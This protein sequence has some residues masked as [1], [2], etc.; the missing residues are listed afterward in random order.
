MTLIPSP[1]PQ[2][3]LVVM[4]RRS[5]CGIP[6]IHKCPFLLSNLT[7]S[8]AYSKHISCLSSGFRF[9]SVC[10]VRRTAS[11]RRLKVR[12]CSPAV[13]VCIRPYL[14]SIESSPRIEL[15]CGLCLIDLRPIAG[16][17][18]I[19]Q[20]SRVRLRRSRNIGSRRMFSPGGGGEPKRARAKLPGAK[21]R[22]PQKSEN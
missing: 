14:S 2:H 21:G 10:A 9:Y 22:V 20:G 6:N 17:P 1:N 3:S 4:M 15:L 18:G 13:V 7:Y 19:R 5:F 11:E 12:V 8:T 16:H